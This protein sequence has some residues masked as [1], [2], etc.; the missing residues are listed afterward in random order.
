MKQ[1]AHFDGT[2][3]DRDVLRWHLAGKAWMEEWVRQSRPTQPGDGP[4]DPERARSYLRGHPRQ[5]RSWP[6][7]PVQHPAQDE[8]R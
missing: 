5:L 8:R 7:V 1:F 3:A 2:P 6:R 4:D